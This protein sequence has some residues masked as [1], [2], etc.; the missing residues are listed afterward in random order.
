MHIFNKNELKKISFNYSFL[1]CEVCALKKLQSLPLTIVR[2]TAIILLRIIHLD[3]MGKISSCIYMIINNGISN[4]W[5]NVI[6][7]QLNTSV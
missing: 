2:T 6:I 3:V 5:F 1:D 4:L 7:I